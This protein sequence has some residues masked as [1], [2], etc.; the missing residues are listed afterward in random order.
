[1]INIPHTDSPLRY[2][3]GKTQMKKFIVDILNTNSIN[4]LYVEPF[5]GGAGVALY[6]LF[7]GHVN[8]I[9][10]NDYDRCIYAFWN[11][12][13][14]NTSEFIYLI[15]N[16]PITI[17]EWYKQKEIQ[18][19]SY[20]YS[21]LEI[22]FSTFFLNRTNVSGII[23]GGPLG[24]KEQRGK[25][26][27]NCRFNKTKLIE[28]INRI[29]EYKDQIFISDQDAEIFIVNEISKMDQKNTFIF[30][31]PPYYKQGKNLYTNFY[32]H[33][34]HVALNKKI[35]SLKEYY[36]ITTYD[37]AKE[38]SEMYSKHN[39]KEYILSYSA[40]KKRKA[41]EL[42]FYSDKLVLPDSK[43]INYLET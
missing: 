7:N 13:L 22:G 37:S 41:S 15:E 40:N 33:E 32:K 4:N 38:I 42:L 34:D 30:L 31:D 6:L 24:G 21:N 2:P 12:I 17:D 1:M 3:G 10:I 28:K 29:A 39:R 9:H 36:W 14:N 5:A 8:T 35:S 23:T 20:N 43:N 27:L 25:Y 16:A 26:K 18:I 11:S 19:N